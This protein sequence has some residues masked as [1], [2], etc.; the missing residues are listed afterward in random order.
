MDILEKD[1]VSV[2]CYPETFEQ[3][4]ENILQDSQKIYLVF[5]HDIK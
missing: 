3:I 5:Q 4:K 1:W 2:F